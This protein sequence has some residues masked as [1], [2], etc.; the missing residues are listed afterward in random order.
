[1]KKINRQDFQL[2]RLTK[3]IAL[4]LPFS[5]QAANFDVTQ[6]TDDGTGNTA[7]T[8]SRAIFLA[9]SSGTDD[10]ITLMNDVTMTG[11][12]KRLINSNITLQS[13]ATRRTI[14]GNNQFRPLFIKSGNVTIQN[15]DLIDGMAKGG[16]SDVGAPGSGMGGSVFIY[17]GNV[18]LKNVSILN[19]TAVGGDNLTDN[20]YIG[21]GGGMSGNAG[22]YGGGGLFASGNG[23]NGG[24]GG[25][26][27][28]NQGEAKFGLGGSLSNNSS[29]NSGGFGGG[30][31]V[32]SGNG[33][34][35]GGG[36]QKSGN[37]TAGDGGFGA[38]APNAGNYSG[39]PGYGASLNASAG[40]GGAVFIRTG[41]INITNSHFE[42]NQAM[43]SGSAQGLGGALFVV[44]STTQS[45]GNNQGMPAQ[46]ATVTGCGNTFNMNSASSDPNTPD[47]ND[48][49]FD[50]GGVVQLCLLVTVGND[51]GTGM[52]E[53]TLSWA[54]KESNANP[55]D[56]TIIFETDVILSTPA[57]GGANNSGLT[58]TP[59]ITGTV[60]MIGNSHTL[61]RD[62]SLTCNINATLETGEFRLLHVAA[63]GNLDIVHMNLKNGCADSDGLGAGGGL[64]NQGTLTVNSVSF[65]NNQAE[66]GGGIFNNYFVDKIQ[67]STFSQNIVT[68]NGG[69][70]YLNNITNELRNNT[71]SENS[72]PLGG[73]AILHFSLNIVI[74]INNLFISNTGPF[75]DC[76]RF[77]TNSISGSNNMSDQDSDFCDVI[78]NTSL[79][80]STV[81]SL[82][83]NGCTLPNVDG[84]CILTHALLRGSQAIDAAV[85]G[86][87]HDQRG[88]S[89]VDNRDIGSFEY[90]GM[91][92]IIFI[93]GFEN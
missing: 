56:D 18:E 21:G 53:N 25:F 5:I 93:S 32:I 64:L 46:L 77:S 16:D 50:L 58:G 14:S 81:G 41:T 44:H 71:F 6:T 67:N 78:D 61:E 38:G 88:F 60:T 29:I 45:N 79:D 48:D 55:G 31:G 7:N 83:D 20:S 24:Y 73:G 4:C 36:A 72:A 84:N 17:D 57:L 26:G 33:G 28:Y 91:R 40:M 35:G 39:N 68:R 69:A 30:G 80:A 89:A 54:I 66:V 70:M 1:M 13:D 11:V 27:N 52:I 62:N 43:G 63:T 74:I 82:E 92:D 19:S 86:T 59:S 90:N 12:M 34:F 22:Y 23:N 75:A 8:L 76:S 2:K 47:N 42:N 10:S 15:L 65:I 49:I 87:S 3:V 9:N 37:V 85:N 51:D